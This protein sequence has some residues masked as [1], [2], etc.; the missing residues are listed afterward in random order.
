MTARPATPTAA[1]A[2]IDGPYRYD[3]T[4]TWG[5]GPRLG[6]VMLNPS[7]ADAAVD[8]PTIRRC[9]GYAKAWGFSGIAVRNLFAYRATRPAELAAAADPVGP[10]GDRWLTRW[11]TVRLVV[12]AWG[13]GR[14]PALHGRAAAAARLLAAV[15]GIDV[16]GL[17][18][19]HDGNPVHP[20]YQPADLRPAA[21][22]PG[23][24]P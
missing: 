17:R 4:R 15:D 8:D 5:P 2:V 1:T 10:D 19:G 11:G 7:T 13:T 3:L 21:W 23:G 14:Y 18:T 24:A 6:W 16:V 12:A 20:L 22:P 9:I